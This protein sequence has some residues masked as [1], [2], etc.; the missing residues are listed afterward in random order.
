MSART[1]ATGIG[2]SPESPPAPVRWIHGGPV[3]RRIGLGSA[4]DDDAAAVPDT[5]ARAERTPVTSRAG[6]AGDDGAFAPIEEASLRALGR[7]GLSRGELALRLSDRGYGREEIAEELDR[8][9]STGL[10]D[11]TSLAVRLVETLQQR[12][13]YGRGA[14][15][16]ALAQR[17][18]S[19]EAADIALAGIDDDT[20][21][22]RACALADKRARSLT[23]LDAHTRT[24]RLTAYLLRRGF[25]GGTVRAAIESVQT[26]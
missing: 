2:E 25:S 15:A 22:R 8:L 3:A 18:V 1:G 19:A 11:D 10:V 17:R 4:G 12:R 5:P 9:E 16:A 13:G 7:R 21:L 20:E 26:G 6:T 23:G 24:R 14:I